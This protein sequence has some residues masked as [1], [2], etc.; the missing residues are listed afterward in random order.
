MA[1]GRRVRRICSRRRDGNCGTSMPQATSVTQ[2]RRGN[3]LEAL[4]G[5]RKGRHSIRTNDQ[6]RVCFIWTEAGPAE[7]EIVDYH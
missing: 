4:T 7:V 3:G 1:S 5:D 2:D 6:F